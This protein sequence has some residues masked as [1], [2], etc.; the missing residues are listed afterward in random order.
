MDHALSVTYIASF[1]KCIYK[2]FHVNSGVSRLIL[3]WLHNA[4]TEKYKCTL[5]LIFTNQK[6][7]RQASSVHQSSIK[8]LVDGN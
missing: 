3:E 1:T 2:T 8:H 7:D 5:R 4:Y 6:F